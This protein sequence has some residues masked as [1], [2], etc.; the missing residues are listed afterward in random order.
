MKE[1]RDRCDLLEALRWAEFAKHVWSYDFMQDR[2][3]DG[4]TYC[5]LNIIDEYNR[6]CLVAKGLPI[7]M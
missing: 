6:E 7:K 2:T 3:Y 4:K 5:N 1:V